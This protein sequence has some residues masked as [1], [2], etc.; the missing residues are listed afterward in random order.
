MRGVLHL[1]RYMPKAATQGGASRA[2]APP[3][4]RTFGALG[5][6]IG[7]LGYANA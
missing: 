7:A 4:L 1:F 5:R 3:L 2:N 6:A